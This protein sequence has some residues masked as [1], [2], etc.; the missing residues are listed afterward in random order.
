MPKVAP[1]LRETSIDE[2]PPQQRCVDAEAPRLDR[3]R[4]AADAVVEDDAKCLAAVSPQ[5]M[6]HH[7]SRVE[8]ARPAR[9]QHA[10]RDARAPAGADPPPRA[11]L[12]VNP[13]DLTKC[14][15][16]AGE[17]R[18]VTERCRP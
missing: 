12:V 1:C 7:G 9:G 10:H 15:H 18:P 17:V 16:A 5:L 3:A 6:T 14:V 11:E 13:A 4:P 2:L 8:T